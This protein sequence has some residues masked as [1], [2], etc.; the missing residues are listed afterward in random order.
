MDVAKEPQHA[1]QLGGACVTH[2]QGR[3]SRGT[4]DDIE[5]HLLARRV[6][7]CAYCGVSSKGSDGWRLTRGVQ[8]A[9]QGLREG[10]LWVN[11]E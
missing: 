5:G 8:A 3:G 4:V 9:N 11:H 1:A 7:A 6:V 2:T 10:A